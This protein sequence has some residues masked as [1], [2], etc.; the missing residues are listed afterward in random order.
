[1]DVMS[2][3]VYKGVMDVM[4]PNGMERLIHVRLM[5][6]MII[7]GCKCLWIQCK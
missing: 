3:N 4:V 6:P 7:I 1:M 5:T 2:V